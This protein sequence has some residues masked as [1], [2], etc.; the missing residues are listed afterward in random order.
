LSGYPLD[1]SGEGLTALRFIHAVHIEFDLDFGKLGAQAYL[2]I[3][4]LLVDPGHLFTHHAFRQAEGGDYPHHAM[5]RELSLHGCQLGHDLLVQHAA[6]FMGNPWKEEK[7]AVTDRHPKARRG[8]YGIVQTAC[9]IGKVSLFAIGFG[10]GAAATAKKGFD[11]FQGPCIEHR[12]DTGGHGRGGRAQIILGGPQPAGDYRH[13]GTAADFD[14]QFREHVQVVTYR[15][16]AG[17]FKTILLQNI[18]DKCR[19]A[20]HQGTGANLIPCSHNLN[21]HM[22]VLVCFKCL[23]PG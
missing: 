12:A 10:H 8:A 3:G 19:I 6:H 5:I 17:D 14:E 15:V 18:G 4:K 11:I 9:A 1:G 23:L 13:I 16:V 7:G 21:A 2:Y 22:H 20:I